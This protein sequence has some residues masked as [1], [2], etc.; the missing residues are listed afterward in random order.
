MSEIDERQSAVQEVFRCLMVEKDSETSTPQLGVRTLRTA[1]LPQGDVTLRVHYSSLNYKDA[2]AA[3][4][5]RGVVRR[6]PHI[7]GID[8]AGTVVSTQCEQI[9]V[10]DSVLVTGY[11]LGQGHWGGW[12]ELVR[13]P[14]DWVVPLPSGLTLRESMILGT[15][16]FTAAQSIAALQRNEVLP[17]D[18]PIVV[19]G[20]SGGVG[21][22]AVRMLARLGYKVVG[23]SGKPNIHD[24]LL[25]FGA[26]EVLDRNALIDQS[27]K[28]MLS[29][30]WAGAVDTVGGPLLE[31]LIKTTGY[32]GCVTTC[33]LVA[34]DA[35]ELSLFPFL[36]RGISLC[37][38]ASA[39]CPRN[40]RERIWQLLADAW[41]PGDLNALVNEVA[42]EE[43][44]AQVH[45]IL[46]GNIAGRT[47]VRP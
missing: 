7:P 46:G 29:A 12:S 30:T 19:T 32:G 34:G 31:T 47:L 16:G 3:S 27:G 24:Q 40:K 39:D 28:P 42:L 4:G 10:G 33:G 37:G 9:A 14:S 15:A 8:A 44:P 38:I 26:A 41:K 1:E 36:L 13:V 6:L 17:G 20:A 5:H 18:G 43:V 45:E 21:S 2:L 22:M 11:D 35:L 25:A 23:I